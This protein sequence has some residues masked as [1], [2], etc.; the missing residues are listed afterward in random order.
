MAETNE[1]FADEDASA[2]AGR[3]RR[4]RLRSIIVS[5]LLIALAAAAV[6]LQWADWV[7]PVRAAVV[8]TFVV[9][10]PGWAILRLW[11]L[12]GG[13]VGA[14]LVI[15]FSLSLAMIVSG[16]TVYAGIWSPLGALCG[17]AAVTI[18]A[19][20]ISLIQGRVHTTSAPIVHP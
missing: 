17:L 16:A 3:D 13:W 1:L 12:A 7:V 11:N 18:L 5:S 9:I 15:A 6:A 20:G 8:L 10:G 2:D 19:A 14:G 4:T